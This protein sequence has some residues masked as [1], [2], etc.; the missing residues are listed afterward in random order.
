MQFGAYAVGDLGRA[1]FIGKG[2]PG[3][4]GSTQVRRLTISNGGDPRLFALHSTEV[5]RGKP[6]ED[7]GDRTISFQHERRPPGAAAS[8]AST[9]R[10]L[11]AAPLAGSCFDRIWG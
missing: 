3:Y 2:L 7:Y 5:G 11:V 10:Q 6:K 1:L 9:R 8:R 4:R